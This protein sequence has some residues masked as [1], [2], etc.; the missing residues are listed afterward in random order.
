LRVLLDARG[1]VPA[2]GPLFDLALASTLV[3]TT[4]L[5]PSAALDSWR[6]AGAKVEILPAADDG[7]GVD[8]PRALEV[9]GHDGVLQAMIEGG[10]TLHGALWR[11]GLV[12]RVVVYLAGALLGTGGR[13]VF[14]WPGPATLDD[15]PRLELLDVTVLDHDVRLDFAAP[16]RG[17]AV[18]ECH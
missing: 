12:D 1:R 5:A 15:A 17:A 18:A 13:P 9:L 4:E 10:P 8:L 7:T 3:L 11:A 16:P 14:E 6:A 2:T